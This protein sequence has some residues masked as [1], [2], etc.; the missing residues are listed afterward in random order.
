MILNDQRGTHV[1][2]SA[3][4]QQDITKGFYDRTVKNGIKDPF[5]INQLAFES[6]KNHLQ[7]QILS[8]KQRATT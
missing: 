8:R 2:S 5:K 3:R 4:N 7:T 6:T 1:V